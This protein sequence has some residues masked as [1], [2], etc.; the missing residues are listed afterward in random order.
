MDNNATGT[1]LSDLTK[2]NAGANIWTP[3][4]S[5]RWHLPSG[6]GQPILQQMWINRLGHAE[7]RDIPIICG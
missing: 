2:D 7:W 3:S 1:I 6:T 4:L 5:L